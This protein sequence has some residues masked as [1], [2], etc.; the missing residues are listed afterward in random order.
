MSF[1]KTILGSAAA[2]ALSATAALADPA[3]IFDLGGKF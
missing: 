1:T 2:V 3:I